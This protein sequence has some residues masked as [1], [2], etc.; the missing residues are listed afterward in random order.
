MAC[1]SDVA[2]VSPAPAR[3]CSCAW[4]IVVQFIGDHSNSADADDLMIT[5]GTY[6]GE[7]EGIGVYYHTVRV[8][9]PNDAIAYA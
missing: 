8:L 9:D 3:T 6:E 7:N 1:L 2:C 4:L 5:V